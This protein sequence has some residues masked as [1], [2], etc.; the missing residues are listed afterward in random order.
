MA[1]EAPVAHE[2]AKKCMGGLLSETSLVKAEQA[3]SEATGSRARIHRR[4]RR[5]SDS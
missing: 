5:E 3:K 2:G 4:T 1:D